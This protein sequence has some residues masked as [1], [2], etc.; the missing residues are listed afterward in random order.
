MPRGS[1]VLKHGALEEALNDGFV[2]FLSLFHQGI[3]LVLHICHGLG[4]ALRRGIFPS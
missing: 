1:L 2:E 4:S 3:H